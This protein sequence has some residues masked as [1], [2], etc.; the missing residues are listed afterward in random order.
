MLNRRNRGQRAALPRTQFN[1]ECPNAEDLFIGGGR[2]I[3][4]VDACHRS[5]P[6]PRWS[7]WRGRGFSAGPAGSSRR[8]ACTAGCPAKVFATAARQ[9]T[10][11]TY[12]QS[13]AGR[14]RAGAKSGRTASRHRA[15]TSGGTAASCWRARGRAAPSGR[16]AAC[17]R[18]R[19][20]ARPRRRAAAAAAAPMS[21]GKPPRSSAPSNNAPKSKGS[22]ANG[23]VWRGNRT[24]RRVRPSTSSYVRSGR[25]YP[26]T[27][28]R[29]CVAPSQWIGIAWPRCVSRNGS[30]T[31][32]PAA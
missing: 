21:G 13:P 12:G 18:H 22:R 15:A 2:V 29:A 14:R 24:T 25:N 4:G 11:A 28:T 3:R 19:A 17:P 6:R 7:S 9:R 23:R 10:A 30:A 16:T 31:A 5:R 20:A 8:A 1:Q 27:S 26:P 32:F